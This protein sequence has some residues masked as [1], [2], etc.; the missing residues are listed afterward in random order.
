MW[1]YRSHEYLATDGVA[2]YDP[3]KVLI[4]ITD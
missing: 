1:V 3:L 2:G 4:E